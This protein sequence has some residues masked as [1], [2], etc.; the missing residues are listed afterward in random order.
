[1]V[2]PLYLLRL[3]V[4]ICSIV[5]PA[6]AAEFSVSPIRAEFKPGVI[7]ETITVTNDGATPLKAA[8]KLMEWTQDA[9]GKDVYTESADLVYF[10][11]EFEVQGGGRR[12]IRVGTKAPAGT[13][14]RTYRLFVE[15]VPPNRPS[16][17]RA[18]VAFHFSFAVPIFLTPAVPRVQLEVADPVVTRGKLSAVVRNT[19]NQ[20]ARLIKVRITD[21]ASFSVDLP[22]WYLLAGSQRSHDTE[23]P[24][25]VCR[26]GRPLKIQVE[27]EGGQS[28]ER[29][30]NVDPAHCA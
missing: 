28:L 8:V 23:L 21:D 18:E 26:R 29:A 6:L 24:R 19:G 22:G 5:S 20:H 9:S 30:F 12:L 27:S 3:I 17:A 16:A 25:E 2:F 13:V 1:M 14:E 15:E 10:P 4:V 7:S 11:R